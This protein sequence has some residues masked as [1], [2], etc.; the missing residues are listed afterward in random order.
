MTEE[1]QVGTHG[2][3]EQCAIARWR[4]SLRDHHVYAVAVSKML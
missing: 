1:A 2:E 3:H 4:W